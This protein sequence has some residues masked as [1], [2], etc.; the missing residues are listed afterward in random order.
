M[1]VIVMGVSVV[2]C[3]C[4]RDKITVVCLCHKYI[5]LSFL[6]QLIIRFLRNSLA[7]HK[8][9]QEFDHTIHAILCWGDNRSAVAHCVAKF[10]SQHNGVKD[11]VKQLD[12]CVGILQIES[13]S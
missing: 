10:C 1:N 9:F 2:S 3:F 13:G 11:P 7:V 12:S 4:C 6:K 5:Y 8:E